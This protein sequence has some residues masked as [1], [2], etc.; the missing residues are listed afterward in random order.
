MPALQKS[1]ALLLALLVLWQSATPAQAGA[2]ARRLPLVGL[3]L[4][5]PKLKTL[6]KGA[7]VVGGAIL[8]HNAIKGNQQQAQPQALPGAQAAQGSPNPGPEDPFKCLIETIKDPQLRAEALA[9]IKEKGKKLVEIPF[10]KEAFFDRYLNRARQDLLRRPAR[11]SAPYNKDFRSR[12][13]KEIGPPPGTGYH[14]DH[15]VERCLGGD[16][17]AKTNGKW[18]EGFINEECG[19]K[20]GRQVSKDP[21][22]TQYHPVQEPKK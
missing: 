14:A 6:V 17:C 11:G 8:V 12:L 22:G 19:R 13:Q 20:I 1:L 10:E 21:A 4:P 16:D 7:V 3:L 15:I 5:A 2:I 18:L 9:A